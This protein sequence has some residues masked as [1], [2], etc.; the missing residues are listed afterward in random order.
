METVL[1]REHKWDQTQCAY[2]G[3]HGKQF[4]CE[5]CLKETLDEMQNEIDWLTG[6][7]KELE[8]RR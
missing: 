6:K 4:V 7:I 8:A 3:R 5:R 2:C 1:E